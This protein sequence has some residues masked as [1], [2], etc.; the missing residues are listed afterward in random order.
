M[1]GIKAVLGGKFIILP[2]GM[3]KILDKQP[4]LTPKAT[5][6]RKT[7]KIQSQQKERNHKDQSRN[8]CNRDK[9]NK[10]KDQ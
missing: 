5:R 6:E 1:G 9:E 3:R 4:N 2:Q 7:N 10:I 8:K